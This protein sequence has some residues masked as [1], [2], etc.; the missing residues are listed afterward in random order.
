MLLEL[1]AWLTESTIYRVNRVPEISK[2]QFLR[3]LG[4]KFIAAQPATLKLQVALLAIGSQTQPIPEIW[5]LPRGTFVAAYDY[6]TMRPTIFETLHEITLARAGSPAVVMARQTAR[7]Q[8]ELVGTSTGETLQL[9]RLTQ[10]AVVPPPMPFPVPPSVRVTPHSEGGEE[11][12]PENWAFVRNFQQSGNSDKQFTIKP[13]LNAIAFGDGERGAIPPQDASID[14]NYRFAP[15]VAGEVMN[16]NVGRSSARARQHFRLQ[17]PVLALDLELPS[18]LEPSMLVTLPD[19]TEA[20]N[21]NYRSS[22]LEMRGGEGV[23]H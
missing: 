17:H 19:E 3:M 8:D 18:T 15:T 16:E 12:C 23:H 10:T 14:V 5:T 20:E 6:L 1:F 21:W 13:T 9:F 4:A 7:V 11:Q 2:I 22:V